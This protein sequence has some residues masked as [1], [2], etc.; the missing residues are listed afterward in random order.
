MKT[1]TFCFVLFVLAFCQNIFA[2]LT[3]VGTVS[4]S[5]FISN[6]N[7]KTEI[8]NEAIDWS[9]AVNQG[10]QSKN[11]SLVVVG[12]AQSYNFIN[13]GLFFAFPIPNL[14]GDYAPEIC[15]TNSK[16]NWE[17][18]SYGGYLDGYPIPG[19]A[20]AKFLWEYG[21]SSNHFSPFILNI[22]GN[23]ATMIGGNF[24][25]LGTTPSQDKII[26]TAYSGAN[27]LG[28]MGSATVS[29][30]NVADWVNN[31]LG[32][33]ATK[34]GK[35]M[36]IKSLGIDYSTNLNAGNPAVANLMFV[37]FPTWYGGTNFSDSANWTNGIL[38]QM[39]A[40]NSVTGDFALADN[41]AITAG[42]GKTFTVSGNISGTGQLSETGPGLL[43]LS[44]TENNWSGGTS[45]SAGTLEFSGAGSFPNGTSLSV[46]NSASRL[47]ASEFSAANKPVSG[48]PEP[49]NLALLV[50]GTVAYFARRKF[51]RTG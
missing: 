23:G 38:P 20:G 9:N 51:H 24:E 45:V 26:L 16:Q 8:F 25:M 31:F 30:C 3:T 43:I 46:G 40:S 37:Q 28:L 17:F 21:N 27:G 18:G 1:A 22:P 47:F 41:L 11:G 12:T 6:P 33:Q 4:Q 10:N 29:A 14:I 7:N 42:A 48:V 13:T 19:G 2:Q 36:P 35:T 39:S 49:C 50:A 15:L 44:G 34:N 5:S 32:I